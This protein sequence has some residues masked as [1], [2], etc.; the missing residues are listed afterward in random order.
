MSEIFD[1]AFRTFAVVN[2]N[3]LWRTCQCNGLTGLLTVNFYSRQCL[4]N[5]LACS[6]FLQ[7]QTW[8]LCGKGR[9]NSLTYKERLTSRLYFASLL[10]WVTN[11]GN[12]LCFRR[13][14]WWCHVRKRIDQ[15]FMAEW[16]RWDLNILIWGWKALDVTVVVAPNDQNKSCQREHIPIR[17]GRCVYAISS[18]TGY[19]MMCAAFQENFEKPLM[20]YKFPPRAECMSLLL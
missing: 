13:W 8:G 4:P 15:L 3:A 18:R 11:F 10:R 9:K 14:W 20:G 6:A 17:S 2:L 7:N 16:R 12:G 1:G 5:D 19:N